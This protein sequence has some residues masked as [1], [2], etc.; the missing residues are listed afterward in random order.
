[1]AT[2]KPA[3][4]IYVG[5]LVISALVAVACRKK[6]APL[7]VASYV[8]VKRYTGQWYEIARLPN[9]FQKGCYATT[10]RYT[11]QPDGTIAVLNS[12]NKGSVQGKLKQAE[13]KAFVADTS[14]NAKLKVQF[15][16]PFK[17]DYWILD[18]GEE[19]EYAVVGEPSRENMWILSR[20]P[21]LD[22][23]IVDRIISKANRQGFDTSQLIFTAHK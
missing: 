9:S 16:W 8:D 21:D 14:T 17:G 20:Q 4:Q 18:V 6:H 19:Y 12:C 3:V 7:E 2:I 1:M 15:F 11:L 13:G 22:K 10:A 23:N 5:L